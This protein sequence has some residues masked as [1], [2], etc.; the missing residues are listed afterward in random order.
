MRKILI[1][2]LSVLLIMGTLSCLMMPVSAETDTV[3]PVNLIVNG[4]VN[5]VDGKTVYTKEDEEKSSYKG[6]FDE[7]APVG[8]RDL[9]AEWHNIKLLYP[10][11]FDVADGSYKNYS[12]TAAIGLNSWQSMAQDI[13]IESGKTYKVSAKVTLTAGNSTQTGRMINMGMDAQ[14]QMQTPAFAT[15]KPWYTSHALTFGTV[16]DKAGTET[17]VWTGDFADISFTFNADDFIKYNNLTAG[18]DN[19]YHARLVFENYCTGFALFDDITMYEV[20]PFTAEP[21]NQ[22][23]IYGG[24]VTGDKAGVIGQNAT[25]TAVP[26]YG[27]TFEGWYSG[28]T[29]VSTDPAYTFAVTANTTLTAKFNINNLWPDSGYENTAAE[30]ALLYDKV[31]GVSTN[32]LWYSESVSK[33]WSGKV[34]NQKAA[35]GNHCAAMTHRNNYFNLK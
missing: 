14:T 22:N 10:A 12:A 21:A 13:R 34:S 32:G 15:A 4:D 11:T 7:N 5:G 30:T 18:D 29:R 9:S 1:T 19:K 25:V 23:G 8:W 31:G 27:N 35:D 3:T 6:E 17:T 26:Y 28:D 33:W 16:T 20:T 2:V 24:Y